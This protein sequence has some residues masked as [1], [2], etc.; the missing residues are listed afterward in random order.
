MLKSIIAVIFSKINFIIATLTGCFASQIQYLEGTD[1]KYAVRRGFA[2]YSIIF[3][4]L[5]PMMFSLGIFAMMIFFMIANIKLGGLTMVML[6]DFGTLM[7]GEHLPILFKHCSYIAGFIIF[8]YFLSVITDE[9]IPKIS[10]KTIN[11]SF[12]KVGDAIA[13]KI[14]S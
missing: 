6:I 14:K 2:K 11:E 3:L 9:I 13:E 12:D 10:K 4:F 1:P 8:L 7:F 5:I